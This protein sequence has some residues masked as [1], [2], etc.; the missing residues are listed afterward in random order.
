MTAD[1]DMAVV[2]GESEVYRRRER[3][4]DMRWGTP[5][6]VKAEFGIGVAVLK[7]AWGSGWVRAR[8]GCWVTD[9]RR[10]QTI[11]CFE[12]IQE[13]IERVMYRVSKSYAERWWTD[14][15]VR[16]MREGMPDGPYRRKV[17][18]GSKPRKDGGDS[19]RK[20]RENDPPAGAALDP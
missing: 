14:N 5:A 13:F 1:V 2:R 10:A 9:G 6:Q 8:Q 17:L 12:D 7:A 15:I 18:H 16:Q 4:Y 20:V 3:P 19:V 11:F